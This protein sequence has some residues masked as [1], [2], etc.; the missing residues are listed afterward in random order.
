[1]NLAEKYM[2]PN[3]TKTCNS[4][5]NLNLDASNVF[6]ALEHADSF[7]N[8]HLASECWYFLDKNAKEVLFR[9][10]FLA[11]ERSVKR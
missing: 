9:A 10:E 3:L 7:S 4:F 6:S 2:V 1:M 11:T 5:L 8:D